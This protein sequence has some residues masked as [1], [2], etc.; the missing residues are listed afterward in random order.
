MSR[1]TGPFVISMAG[2]MRSQSLLQNAVSTRRAGPPVAAIFSGEPVI[3][4][5]NG[6]R[7][8]WLN[9]IRRSLAESQE[10]SRMPVQN[11]KGGVLRIL[12]IGKFYP[13]HPGGMETHLEQLSVNLQKF[14][15][16]Q[17]VVSNTGRKS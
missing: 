17:V 11:N 10:A 2:L 14:A 1:L 16:V 12:Q 13:P 7:I 15:H 5:G 4:R 9:C 8:A 6:I 3:F